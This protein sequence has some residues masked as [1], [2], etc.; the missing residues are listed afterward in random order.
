MANDPILLQCAVETLKFRE[1]IIHICC[2]SQRRPTVAL[3]LFCALCN[4]RPYSCVPS[5]GS[6]CLNTPKERFRAC[7]ATIEGEHGFI[8]AVSL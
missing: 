3:N 5:Q 2:C 8:N 7:V 6:L 4:V 1:C